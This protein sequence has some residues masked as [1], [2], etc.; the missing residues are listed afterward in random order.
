MLF[1][2]NTLITTLANIF[3]G[4]FIYL[5]NP[6]KPENR[7]FILLTFSLALWIATLYVYYNVTDPHWLLFFGRINF[8][9]PTLTMYYLFR[10]TY[11]FPEPSIHLSK[12]VMK[13]IGFLALV[14]SL[15]AAFTP[16]IA[17]AE[18]IVGT[19]RIVDYG[20]MYH[21]WV[22]YFIGL[23]I[24]ALGLLFVKLRKAVG[25]SKSQLK[26]LLAGTGLAYF[27]GVFTNIILPYGFGVYIFQPVGPLGTLFLTGLTAYAIVR[28]KFLDITS[29]VSR[30]VSYT[31]LLASVVLIEVGIL[32]VGTLILPGNFDK[33]IIAFV[34]SILIVMGYSNLNTAITRLT[35]SIFFQGRYNQESLLKTLT[36]IMVNEMDV[37]FL[38][39][40]LIKILTEQ[41]KV[42][43]ASFLLISDFIAKKIPTIEFGI[44]PNVKYKALEG[45]LHKV[46][47]TMIF[48]DMTE[49][50]DKEIFRK[51]G[52]S[53]ILPLKVGDEDIGLF[54]LGTKL[55]GEM[56]SQRDIDTLEIFAPQAAIALKNA[57]SY[58]QIQ[59]FNR[60]LEAKVIDR[61][62]EL[63]IA[64]ASELKLKDEFVFIA[65][66]DLATPVTAISGFSALINKSN[67]VL[68]P[69]LKSNLEAITE[70]SNRLKVLVN[71]LLQIARSDSGTIKLDVKDVD[72]R[73]ILEAAVREL[74][75]LATEKKVKIKLELGSDNNMKGDATKLSEVCENLMSNSIKYN[76]PGGSL[77]ISSRVEEN[78]YIIDFKDTG[79]GIPESEQSKV[80]TKFFRSE[81]PEVRQRPGTGLGLFV[82]RM[83]TEKMGGEIAFESIVDQGTTF[84][85]TFNR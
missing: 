27:F 23:P 41:M 58:R 72:A 59:E 76:N 71:D 48:E 68:S 52:I 85:L 36:T 78:K 11:F 2:L 60:T 63:E 62:H 30:A 31:L 80:F 26:Y 57:D 82:A 46:G 7:V 43:S 54:I 38:K 74:T 22:A 18:T 17:R 84:S 75:P 51:L 69:Q 25:R 66:H 14:M 33:T 34:G 83:L 21:L 15:L 1:A 3:L 9:F 28:Y 42:S 4:I 5:R 39:L 13:L 77:T 67:E 20:P 49:E 70:A 6:S 35:D 53:I 8:A 81:E 79:I 45:M 12:I 32:W 55:S 50:A 65:T 40:K 29:V 19:E 44:P 56:Y 24:F 16:F 64:Q 10:F 47:K 37:K 73:S 61:T